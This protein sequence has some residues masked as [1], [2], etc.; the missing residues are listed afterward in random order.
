MPRLLCSEVEIKV[1]A[2]TVWQVF[3]KDFIDLFPKLL[4]NVCADVQI[5][6]GDGGVGTVLLF[7]FGAGVQKGITYQKERIVEKDEE[8]R[9]V[10]L[11]VV[12][13]AHKQLGFSYC[14]TTFQMKENGESSTVIHCSVEY[15]TIEGKPI[16]MHTTEA[17][18]A[19]FKGIES[20]ILS[21]SA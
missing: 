9:I 6:E 3:T 21:K 16:S 14:K 20:H 17:T 5:L 10:A 11:E 13:G 19:L 2:S 4:P 18:L 12:E 8:K 1:P 15:E 7:N